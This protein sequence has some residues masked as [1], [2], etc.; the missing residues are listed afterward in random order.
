M[1]KQLRPFLQPFFHIS[2]GFLTVLLLLYIIYLNH[3]VE[4][5]AAYRNSEFRFIGCPRFFDSH[6]KYIFGVSN[7]ALFAKFISHF[8]LVSHNVYCLYTSFDRTPG[9]AWH[10]W[11]SVDWKASVCGYSYSNWIF[12]K[13]FHLFCKVIYTF[14]SFSSQCRLFPY[15]FR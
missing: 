11:V 4:F 6:I 2:D 10:Q 12:C 9:D 8:W 7:F 15:I 1:G 13:Q 3:T 5:E 14:L